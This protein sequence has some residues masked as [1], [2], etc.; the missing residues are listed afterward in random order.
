VLAQDPWH[1]TARYEL[2]R[3]LGRTGQ[4]AEAEREAAE[5]SRQNEAVRLLHDSRTQPDNLELRARA[6]EMLRR[7]G[8]PTEGIRRLGEILARYPNQPASLLLL[9]TQ[10]VV[11]GPGG[12]TGR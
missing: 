12:E 9:A 5:L 8:G 2:S 7:I 4:T 11:K 10:P 6:A 1:P 3:A